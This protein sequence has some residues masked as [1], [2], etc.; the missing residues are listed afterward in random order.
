VA[1]T[2]PGPGGGW[3]PGGGGGCGYNPLPRGDELAL[4]YAAFLLPFVQD[5]SVL[6]APF[7][8]TVLLYALLAQHRSRAYWQSALVYLELLLISQYTY[9]VLLHCLCN[10]SSGGSSSPAPASAPHQTREAAHRASPAMAGSRTLDWYGA[11]R[12]WGCID[13][14]GTVS[15][16]LCATSSRS[17]TPTTWPRCTPTSSRCK[18]QVLRQHQ[19][20]CLVQLAP[21]P[22][23]AAQQR[24]A[25]AVAAAGRVTG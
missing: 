8:L 10:S 17:C 6:T 3:C 24:L 16:S 21:M 5:M 1:A 11:W 9:Q 19:A 20:A 7:P 2:R 12:C 13:H 18:G 22:L 25:M 14:P 23:A 15:P 4:V